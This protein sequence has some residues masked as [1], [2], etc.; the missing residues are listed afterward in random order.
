VPKAYVGPERFVHNDLQPEHI[1]VYPESGRLSGIIDWTGASL[2]DPTL[3]FSYLLV[4][5]GKEFLEAAL[6]T[7]SLPTDPDFVTRTRF[8][9]RVRALGWLVYALYRQVDL[10]RVL[11]EVEN[12]F[13]A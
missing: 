1:L 10:T 3:D 9:A 7:Y 13:S 4:L 5:H 2:G 12:A 6:D 8:R 11:R